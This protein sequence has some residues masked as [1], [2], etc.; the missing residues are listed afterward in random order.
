MGMTVL[1][2]TGPVLNDYCT[3]GYFRTGLH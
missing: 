2:F 3:A 1:E